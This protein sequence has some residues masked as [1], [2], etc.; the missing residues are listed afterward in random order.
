MNFLKIYV[1]CELKYLQK[2]CDLWISNAQVT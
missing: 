1:N 2:N